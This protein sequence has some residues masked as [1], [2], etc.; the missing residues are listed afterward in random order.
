MTIHTEDP[1]GY[2]VVGS[3]GRVVDRYGAVAP[4]TRRMRRAARAPRQMRRG[5]QE[6]AATR[7]PLYHPRRNMRS[8]AADC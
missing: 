3:L 2:K 7:Q 6:E 8:L 4:S 1:L 5:L